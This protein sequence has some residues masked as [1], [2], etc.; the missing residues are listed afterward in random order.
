M[1]FTRYKCSLA[2]IYY[3]YFYFINYIYVENIL[4]SRLNS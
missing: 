2:D 1:M 4:S 3:I